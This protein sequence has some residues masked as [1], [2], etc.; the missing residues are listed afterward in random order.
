ML[1][2]RKIKK[3]KVVIRCHTETA[4]SQT[5]SKTKTSTAVFVSVIVRGRDR[6]QN[7]EDILGMMIVCWGGRRVLSMTRDCVN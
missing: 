5:W 1:K 4:S 7:R 2:P 6:L 3:K